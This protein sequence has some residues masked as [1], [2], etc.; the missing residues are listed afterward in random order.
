MPIE[1]QEVTIQEIK[2]ILKPKGHIYLFADTSGNA[3]KEGKEPSKFTKDILVQE[4]KGSY[5]SKARWQEILNHFK[6]ENYTIQ[7]K[8]WSQ[9]FLTKVR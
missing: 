9:A 5:V 7:T 2:R 8:K 1:D 4:V 3:Y 6:D